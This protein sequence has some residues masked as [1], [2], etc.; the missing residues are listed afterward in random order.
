M[1]EI[2]REGISAGVD[3]PAR[4][5]SEGLLVQRYGPSWPS[6][7]DVNTIF[8][9]RS[10]RSHMSKKVISI[11]LSSSQNTLL[12]EACKRLGMN[13]SEAISAAIRLLP[14][15]ISEGGKLIERQPFFLESLARDSHD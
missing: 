8:S 12:E 10:Y 3:D 14:H 6:Y 7:Y 9:I 2:A 13:R 5:N 15:Y 11:R 1:L 4:P